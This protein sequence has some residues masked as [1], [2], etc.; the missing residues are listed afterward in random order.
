MYCL[1]IEYRVIVLLVARFRFLGSERESGLWFRMEKNMVV[2]GMY[3]ALKMNPVYFFEWKSD[4]WRDFFSFQ[5][6][7]RSIL[8]FWSF[9]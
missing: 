6:D 7:Y 3:H 9:N 5:C 2:C 8:V 4:L 1:K